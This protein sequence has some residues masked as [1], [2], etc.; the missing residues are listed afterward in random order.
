MVLQSILLAAQFIAFCEAIDS[1]HGYVL[2]A[3]LVRE[4]GE[5]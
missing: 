4:Q 3:D 5:F 1:E 2:V